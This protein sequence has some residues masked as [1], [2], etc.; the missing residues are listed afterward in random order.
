MPWVEAGR[1]QP[2]LTPAAATHVMT[3]N[4]PRYSY[5]SRTMHG[6]DNSEFP[7]GEV[8]RDLL[9]RADRIH[10]EKHGGTV[11][12][13]QLL[14]RV[15]RREAHREVGHLHTADLDLANEHNI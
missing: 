1:E 4:R 8:D 3:I 10:A 5:I 15:G 13:P 11:L 7:I 12:E 9:E 6:H 2:P 14:E